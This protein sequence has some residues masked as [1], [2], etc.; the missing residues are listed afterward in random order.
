MVWR[1]KKETTEVKVARAAGR[2]AGKAVRT[3]SIEIRPIMK[4]PGM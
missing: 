3:G 2:M 4:I 1:R